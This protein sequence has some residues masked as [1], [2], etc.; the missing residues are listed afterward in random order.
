[1]AKHCKSTIL[2]F[3]FFK[4]RGGGCTVLI[5]PVCFSQPVPFP[6]SLHAHS[7][8]FLNSTRARNHASCFKV[9]QLQSCWEVSSPV[10]LILTEQDKSGHQKPITVPGRRL[11]HPGS[12]DWGALGNIHRAPISHHGGR[13][14]P[15][16]GL[17]TFHGL[18]HFEFSTVP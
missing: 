16:M 2:Y 9:L 17:S 14:S 15:G 10:S 8:N 7:T 1:M 4:K 6:P 11:E 13:G 12:H 18:R 5:Q 3:F